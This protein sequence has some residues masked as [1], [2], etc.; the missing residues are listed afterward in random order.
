MALT[1]GMIEVLVQ[2]P[3]LAWQASPFDTGEIL[4]LN[5]GF[6]IAPND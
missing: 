3:T 6:R 5:L 1:A 2:A 4:S